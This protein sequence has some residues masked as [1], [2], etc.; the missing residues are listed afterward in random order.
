V[1]RVVQP[2]TLSRR[3]KNSPSRTLRG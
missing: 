2:F 3:R 1:Q